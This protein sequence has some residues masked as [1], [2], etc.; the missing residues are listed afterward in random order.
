MPPRV[1]PYP[2]GVIID[3]LRAQREV[4]QGALADALRDAGR[5][6]ADLDAALDRCGASQ[7]RLDAAQAALST[8]AA[9]RLSAAEL[10]HH[11]KFSQACRASLARAETAIVGCQAALERA[12]TRVGR[13]GVIARGAYLQLKA[14]MM[15]ARMAP[16]KFTIRTMI[17]AVSNQNTT[18]T[19]CRVRSPDLSSS[20]S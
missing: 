19:P 2:L 18:I 11:W 9:G 20:T 5:A 15:F 17:P 16:T 8:A 6:R 1:P 3:Q 4:S 7:A 10:E 13:G 14:S 12:R